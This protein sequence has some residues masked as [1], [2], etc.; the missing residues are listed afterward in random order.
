MSDEINN[1][2]VDEVESVEPEQQEENGRV[3]NSS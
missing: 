1:E 3:I 2:E